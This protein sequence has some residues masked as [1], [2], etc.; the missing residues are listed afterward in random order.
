ML[1]LQRE[2]H[3]VSGLRTSNFVKTLERWNI[4]AT[5]VSEKCDAGPSPINTVNVTVSVK[6]V[7]GLQ[8]YWVQ[9]TCTSPQTIVA[10]KHNSRHGITPGKHVSKFSVQ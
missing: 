10:N 6:S 3:C 9:Q 1:D 5:S 4:I 7:S 2:H 8:D